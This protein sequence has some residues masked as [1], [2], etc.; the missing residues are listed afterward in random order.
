MSYTFRLRVFIGYE[1][2]I[3]IEGIYFWSSVVVLPDDVSFT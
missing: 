1:L 3:L 2:H